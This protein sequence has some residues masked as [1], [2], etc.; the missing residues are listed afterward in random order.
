MIGKTL[1]MVGDGGSRSTLAEVAAPLRGGPRGR[2]DARAPTSTARRPTRSSTTIALAADAAT[3][4][5][6][7]VLGDSVDSCAEWGDRDTLGRG[8]QPRLLAAA[9]A[10]RRARCLSSC[11]STAARDLGRATR[12]SSASPRSRSRGGPQFGGQAMWDVIGA[13]RPT[14]T[15]AVFVGRQVVA[16]TPWYHT[17]SAS[18]HE[19]QGCVTPGGGPPDAGAT[20]QCFATSTRLD[21]ALRLWRR[22]HDGAAFAM[23]A[24][25]A[26]RPKATAATAA[27]T[28]TTTATCRRAPSRCGTTAPPPARPSCSSR[29]IRSRSAGVAHRRVAGLSTSRRARPRR[30]PTFS[31]AALKFHDAR[32]CGASSR[33]LQPPRSRLGDAVSAG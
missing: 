30:A 25:P 24:D 5:I 15:G 18:D 6:V 21:A 23:D 12:C 7:L 1:H 2:R 27:A 14:G 11:S 28:A 10:P 20:S 4:A 8:G 13:I 29:A 19:R 32:R 3:R 22:P 33:D 26:R 9:P 31:R 16:G 17:P